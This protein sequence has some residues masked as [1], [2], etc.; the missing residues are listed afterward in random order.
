MNI[1]FLSRLF[2]P[3]IGGVE[4]HTKQLSL[5]LIKRGYKVTVVTTQY[6]S[7]INTK[8]NHQDITIL[9]IP[10]NSAKTKFGVWSWI[11]SHKNLFQ[12][13]DIIHAHDIFWWLFP[14]KISLS[15]KPLYITFHGW[16]GI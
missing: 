16:E 11:N 14:L 15:N 1:V 12:Q 8:D 9:R 4:T 6:E 3:H 13:S 10:K 2:Y 5:E 7:S